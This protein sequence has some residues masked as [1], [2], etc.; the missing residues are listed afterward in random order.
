MWAQLGLIVGLAL[1]IS[2]LASQ[3]SAWLA[4]LATATL[5]AAE[6]GASVW[7]LFA[8]GL[9]LPLANPLLGGVLAFTGVVAWR[10]AI[11]Q[12]QA[13]DL[14]R[15][16]ASVSFRRAWRSRSARAPERVRLGGERRALSVLFSDLQG[17]T[18]FSETVDAEVVSAVVGEYLAAMSKVVFAYD[19]NRRQVHRRRGDG[20]LE[21]AA[22]TMPSTRATP[23]RRRFGMQAALAQLNATWASAADCPPSAC[24][25][26]STAARRAFGNMGTR[27]RF[28]YTAVGDSVNLAAR[29]EPLNNEYGTWICISQSTLDAAGSEF[30]VRYLDLGGGEG[31]DAPVS[32]YELLVAPTR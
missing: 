10:V 22:R 17:F 14:Q 30:L 19:G 1:L 29:L 15:A 8:F 23:A 27:E 3:L 9:Q 21:C 11:E 7:S 4:A 32:V 13:R 2:V 25:S 31:Q 20:L 12:R 26:A 18:S 6:I 24:A 5:L 16:L 28:A